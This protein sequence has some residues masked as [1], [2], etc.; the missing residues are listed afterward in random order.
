[1]LGGC[2]ASINPNLQPGAHFDSMGVTVP[3]RDGGRLMAVVDDKGAKPVFNLSPTSYS[4]SLSAYEQWIQSTGVPIHR[5]FFIDDVR[6]VELGWWAE[7]ECN[8]A[9]LVL[10]G[11]EGVTEGRVTEIAPGATLP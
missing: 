11:Q 5:G 3:A 6:T 7:R 4:K 10:S 2:C 1:M 8:A 9:F